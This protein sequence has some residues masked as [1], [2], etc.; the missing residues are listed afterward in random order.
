[1]ASENS[2]G[3]TPIFLVGLASV[4]LL[5]VPLFA[6]QVELV[7]GD[8]YSGK[9]LSFDTNS[10]VLQNEVLGT[11]NLPRRTV[12]SIHIGATTPQTRLSTNA[13]SL[14]SRIAGTNAVQ[15]NRTAFATSSGTNIM[16]LVRAQFLSD[17]GPEANNKFDE[18]AGGLLNGKLSVEDIRAEAKSAA[19]QVRA[20]KREMGDDATSG[21]DGYL[22]LG[23]S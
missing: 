3:L 13:L 1:M 18:L 23:D 10:V 15:S 4:A 2:R 19:D 12:S 11:V 6:D 8:R 14:P 5:S 22:V 20:L 16:E 17:A 21:L 9:I 7:N